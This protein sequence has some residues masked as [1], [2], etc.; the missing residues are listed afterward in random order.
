[1]GWIGRKAVLE[2]TEDFKHEKL[3]SGTCPNCER[4]FEVLFTKE[5]PDSGF[6][7][8]GFDCECDTYS[9]YPDSGTEHIRD[10][11]FDAAELRHR[12]DR[13]KLLRAAVERHGETREFV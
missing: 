8:A 6:T 5:G 2:E 1:M 11:D 9:Y 12:A 7:P 10:S 13:R 3:V 4:K